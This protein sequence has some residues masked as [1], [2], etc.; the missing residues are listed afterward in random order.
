MANE[1]RRRGAVDDAM[2]VGETQ[3]R[4]QA[5]LKRRSV[6]A[7]GSAHQLRDVLAQRLGGLRLKP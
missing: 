1:E 7:G 4:H 6:P 5:E 3:R 2:V